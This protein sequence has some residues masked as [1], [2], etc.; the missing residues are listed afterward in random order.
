V[1]GQ[2]IS[3]SVGQRDCN[4]PTEI[5]PRCAGRGGQF[6]GQRL[7]RDHHDTASARPQP[8]RFRPCAQRR[9]RAVRQVNVGKDDAEPGSQLIVAQ[10]SEPHGFTAHHKVVHAQKLS[11]LTDT[12]AQI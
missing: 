6:A 8:R 7:D 2:W 3:R 10:C 12:F 5:W 9:C 11:C 1:G 4:R